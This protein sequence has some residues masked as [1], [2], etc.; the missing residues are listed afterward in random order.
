MKRNQKGFTLIEIIAVL[1]ILGILAAIAI[2]KYFDLQ[3][4]A[5]QKA[6]NGA[7]AEGVGRINAYFGKQA[8]HG[9]APS[10]IVYDTTTLG[11]DAGDFSLAYTG[12]SA[13]SGARTLTVTATGVAGSSVASATGTKS[14][15]APQ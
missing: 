11:S 4:N 12:G 2:P 5:K 6:V 10:A 1:V 8:L 14:V 3:E 7:L 15:L 9:D 13:G